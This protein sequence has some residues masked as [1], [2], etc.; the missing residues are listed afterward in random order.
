MAELVT[1]D[2]LQFLAIE[3]LERSGGN[4]HDRV[5]GTEAGG[6]R[7]DAAFV[8]AIH[9]RHANARGDGHLLDHVQQAAFGENSRAGV[10]L[11]SAQ[12]FYDGAPAGAERQI[13][14]ET[15]TGDADE[16]GKRD[17][18]PRFGR[19]IA[20]RLTDAASNARG[21]GERHRDR[22]QHIRCEDQADD[23]NREQ[24][25]ELP[26]F[27]AGAILRGE[28]IHRGVLANQNLTFGAS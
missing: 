10:D 14:V 22:Y 16:H 1:D 24:R 19:L 23:C 21:G 11:P 4:A 6:E 12:H 17:Q 20:Q 13:L 3:R 28:E 18:P 25:N 7:I 27:A 8:D 2:A 15:R 5:V 9:R 26:R